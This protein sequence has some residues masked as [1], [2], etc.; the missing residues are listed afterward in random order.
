MGW[1][2]GVLRRSRLGMG[3]EM[4]VKGGDDDKI[5]KDGSWRL[6]RLSQFNHIFDSQITVNLCV[7]HIRDNDSVAA[8]HP[9]VVVNIMST[10]VR[11]CISGTRT[12]T[13]R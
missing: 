7:E 10:A 6:A 8:Y 9:L 5:R 13:S 4:G 11:R 1:L 2:R 12:P 3:V